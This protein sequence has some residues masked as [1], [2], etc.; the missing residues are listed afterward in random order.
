VLRRSTR[1][2]LRCCCNCSDRPRW[3]SQGNQISHSLIAVLHGPQTGV[4]IEA[5]L[6]RLLLD[7]GQRREPAVGRGRCH[8][9]R[10]GAVQ[11]SFLQ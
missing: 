9:P 4:L 6:P 3:N 8:G 1:S 11:L 5:L 10:W 2:L 7:V